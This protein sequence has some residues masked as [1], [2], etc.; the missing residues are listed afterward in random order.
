[1]DT[2]SYIDT[3]LQCFESKKNGFDCLNKNF[4]VVKPLF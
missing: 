4:N 3:K 2:T 1:M